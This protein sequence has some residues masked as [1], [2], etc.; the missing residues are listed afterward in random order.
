LQDEVAA[1]RAGGKHALA[2]AGIGTGGKQGKDEN[3]GEAAQPMAGG[4][5]FTHV[6]AAFYGSGCGA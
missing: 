6:S 4:I 2:H 3:R 5:H 1:R